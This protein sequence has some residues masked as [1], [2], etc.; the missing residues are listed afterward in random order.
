MVYDIVILGGGAS[1]MV[2]AV[3]LAEKGFNV[4][5]LEQKPR[6]G[7]KILL[8]GNG[9]CNLTN[10]KI[11]PCN[12][13]SD[14]LGIVDEV[15]TKFGSAEVLNF[16]SSIGL[17][18]REK[19]GLVYPMSNKASSVLDCLRN[20]LSKYGVS[21]ITDF[22]LKFADKQDDKFVI[23]SIDDDITQ[24]KKLIIATGS[25]AFQ[26]TSKGLD[27]LREFGH[28]IKEL[29]PALV[30][31][32][33]EDAFLKGLKGVKFNGEIR[34]R[35]GNDL[36]RRE[37]GE[38]LF[39]DYGIS[40]I[41]VMQVS[42]LFSLY[43][44]LSLELDFL[45]HMNLSE[46]AEMLKNNKKFYQGSSVTAEDYLTGIVDRKLGIR[47]LKH[48]GE[49]SLARNLK[50][51]PIKISGHNGFKS[52][53][54]CG[55]GASLDDFCKETL[56]SLH[57]KGLYAIGEVLDAVGDCG[58]YNL[59]WAWASALYASEALGRVEDL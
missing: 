32:R 29:Y 58:G 42:Y 15:I 34:V 54:V 18:T 45:P 11:S 37:K 30:Q 12:Y 52:A 48:G 53:Q 40:G 7:Q 31:L 43:D 38:M 10:L 46:V 49:K 57:V 8:T 23:K 13:H 24:A 3:K 5:L 9:R 27:I 47:L 19:D 20:A 4:G 33:S 50:A 36:L 21:I 1:G 28:S 55:G 35:Q 56:E 51:L 41:A 14:N 6:I 22:S 25:A 26:G 59:H 39:T 44:K 16:F 17:L 2:A